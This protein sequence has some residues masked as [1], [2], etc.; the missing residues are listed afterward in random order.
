MAQVSGGPLQ[1][2]YY[3]G[4]PTCRAQVGVGVLVLFAG[5]MYLS[6]WGASAC[7]KLKLLCCLSL[8]GACVVVSHNQAFLAEFCE[9]LWIMDGV[10]QTGETAKRGEGGAKF[11]IAGKKKKGVG[12]GSGAGGTAAESS[13]RIEK[14]T[15]VDES[16]SADER[17]VARAEF[18]ETKFLEYKTLL[19]KRVVKGL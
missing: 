2:V 16:W 14:F 7:G 9:E 13:V 15:D 10:P 8:Q 11:G 18:V 3:R 5:I 1:T 6:V 12:E 17:D 19:R 4:S